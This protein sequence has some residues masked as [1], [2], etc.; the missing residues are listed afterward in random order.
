MASCL[1]GEV[2]CST[3]SAAGDRS[4]SKN[5]C[6]GDAFFFV[7]RANLVFEIT[8]NAFLWKMVRS[9]VGTLV[10]YERSGKGAADFRRALESRDRG[11][12]G[13]TAPPWGLSLWHV[14]Y[15]GPI[16]YQRREV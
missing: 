16:L 2:D 14:D 9:L 10:D 8:A 13:Q 7:Q 4:L 5:R 15:D 1:R 11:Q 6:I 3:F 12:A